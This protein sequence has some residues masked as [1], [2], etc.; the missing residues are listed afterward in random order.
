MRNTLFTAAIGLG[1]LVLAGACS[2]DPDDAAATG[3]GGGPRGIGAA[4][5]GST[6]GGAT[7]TGGS[8]Q[9]FVEA[10]GGTPGS[11]RFCLSFPAVEPPCDSRVD[12]VETCNVFGMSF[13]IQPRVAELPSAPLTFALL[14]LEASTSGEGG[15]GG[16]ADPSGM[17]FLEAKWNGPIGSAQALEDGTAVV[18]THD[19]KFRIIVP[20]GAVTGYLRPLSPGALADPRL[21]TVAVLADGQILDQQRLFIPAV[22]NCYD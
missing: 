6:T 7:A 18:L 17:Y 10:K 20:E 12:I 16:V 4:I 8:E 22:Q 14:P 2:R 3:I 5:G 19:A 11:D 15:A 1:S 13:V 9:D 21:G